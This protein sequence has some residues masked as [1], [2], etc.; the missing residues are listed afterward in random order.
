MS[1]ATATTTAA[2]AASAP[3]T[4]TGG[5]GGGGA[6]GGAGAGDG[7]ASTTAAITASQWVYT[8]R[9]E[10]AVSRE[11]YTLK[12]DVALPALK[13]GDILVRTLFCSVDPCKYMCSLCFVLLLF[14]LV[15]T[16]AHSAVT[17]V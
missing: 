13:D 3:T 8:K 2:P 7:G 9:P 11:H 1:S 12:H 10:G 4:A 16:R 14:P 15:A 5:V 6:G 17:C